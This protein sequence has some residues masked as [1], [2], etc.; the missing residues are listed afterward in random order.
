MGK[1]VWTENISTFSKSKHKWELRRLSRV[2][3]WSGQPRMFILNK[4]YLIRLCG[5]R[6]VLQYKFFIPLYSSSLSERFIPDCH[7]QDFHHPFSVWHQHHFSHMHQHQWITLVNLMMN[8]VGLIV[9]RLNLETW[10][11]VTMKTVTENGFILS[12]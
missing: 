4:F 8:N 10:W 7:I 3:L 2:F 6:C 12:V 9:I 1:S 11:V 5:R